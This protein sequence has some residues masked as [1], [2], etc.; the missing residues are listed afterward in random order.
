VF[1]S[2]HFRERLGLSGGETSPD[3][4][5]IKEVFERTGAY[6][7]GRRMFDEGE[8]GWP[9]NPPF[10]APV[11]VLTHAARA[12]W[13]R[14]GGTTFFFVTDGIVSALEQA[15]AAAAGKDVRIS[16]G[17]DA[18]RQYI[19]AGLIDECTLHVAPALLGSGLRLLEP[20]QPG[21]LELEQVRSSASPLVTHISYRTVRPPSRQP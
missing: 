7:M 20:L 19:E 2:A 9:E 4:D 21:A 1:R 18:I 15:R 16:G 14:K 10:R 17:A 3:D 11:Y 12:P 5:R 6:V 8:V 13:T